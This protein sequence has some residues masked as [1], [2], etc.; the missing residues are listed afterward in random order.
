MSCVYINLAIP[1]RQIQMLISIKRRQKPAFEMKASFIKSKMAILIQLFG[2][3]QT[4]QIHFLHKLQMLQVSCIFIVGC[5][6]MGQLGAAG[7]ED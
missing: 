7:Y 1:S 4:K 2:F 5:A 3:H 6:G